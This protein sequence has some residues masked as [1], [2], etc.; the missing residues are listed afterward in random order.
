ML[1]VCAFGVVFVFMCSICIY[2][3]LA[4]HDHLTKST[5][6]DVLVKPASDCHDNDDIIT[7]PTVVINRKRI[8]L[9]KDEDD[10]ASLMTNKLTPPANKLVCTSTTVY[11]AHSFIQNIMYH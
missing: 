2:V 1:I 10:L 9:S 7:S 8:R 11:T 5:G 3:Y 6:D 4:K